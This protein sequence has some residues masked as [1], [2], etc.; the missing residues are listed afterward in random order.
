MSK[1]NSASPIE[2]L[3]D[4]SVV[5]PMLLG[6]R[7]YQQYFATQFEDQPCYISP[8]IQMEMYRSYL[9]NVIVF[10][11]LITITPKSQRIT[12]TIDRTQA[13]REIKL[14]DIT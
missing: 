8:Y 9:R 3:L 13:Q 1:S 6:T 5:R 11:A 14:N 7:A 12:E 4:S 2:Y 10:A